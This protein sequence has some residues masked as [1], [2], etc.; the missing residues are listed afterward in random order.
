MVKDSDLNELSTPLFLKPL[1]VGRPNV[2][3][4]DRFLKRV[5]EIFDQMWFTNGGILV[6]QF[7]KELTRY[8]GVKHCIPV[9]NATLGLEIAIRAIGMQAEVLVPS[10]TFVATPHSLAWQGIT[11]VFCDVNPLTHNLDIRKIEKKITPRTTGIIGVHVWGNACEIEALTELAKRRNLHLIFDAA[12]AFGCS[13]Q[14]KMI[15]NFGALE[16]FSFHATKFFNSFEGGAIATNNDDLA[17]KIRLMKNF[18]F[19]AMD[20]VIFPGTNGKMTEIAAAMGLTSLES[21][22]EFIACNKRNYDLYRQCLQSVP[23]IKVFEHPSEQRHNY[24]YVILEINEDEFKMNRDS[25]ME[26]LHSQNVLARRYFFPGCHQM[27]PYQTNPS[28]HLEQ[29]DALSSRVLSLPNGTSVN[30]RDIRAIAS[31]I[32]KCGNQRK[33]PTKGI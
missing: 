8:L 14:G 27:K 31:F 7:E 24:Q 13:H 19:S 15:G 25:L 22:N 28:A 18:G 26:A 17:A 11:P 4:R 2:G 30:E 9:C 12:H 29:T 33:N 6:Q 20:Q 32:R 1:H 3:N 21:I 23:G 5:H 10:F 16:V